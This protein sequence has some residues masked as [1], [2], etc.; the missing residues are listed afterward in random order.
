MV[1]G[2]S[3]DAPFNGAREEP[4]HDAFG[5]LP[6]LAPPLI[7]DPRV[8]GSITQPEIIVR[9]KLQT[10][11]LDPATTSRLIPDCPKDLWLFRATRDDGFRLSVATHAEP[12]SGQY[13]C[14][15]LRIVPEAMINRHFD[16]D[17][18]AL[19]LGIEM[20][21]KGSF[22]RMTGIAGPR[23]IEAFEKI[24]F[25]KY[26][27]LP[28]L[29]YRVG[30]N[31]DL[32]TMGFIVDALTA[33]EDEFG[34]MAITGQDAGHGDLSNGEKSLDYIADRFVGSGKLNTGEPTGHGNFALL[35]GMFKGLGKNL[36]DS[37]IALFGCGNVGGPLLVRI[38]EHG[39]QDIFVC[40]GVD[41]KRR[42]LA[43]SLGINKV[44][45]E[46]R[47]EELLNYKI[48]AV[49]FN[50]LGKSL[51]NATI[52]AI[53]NNPHIQIVSG[54]ENMIWPDQSQEERFLEARKIMSPTELCG[55][56]GWLA[57]A[58]ESLARRAGDETFSMRQMLKPLDKMAEVG[59][60]VVKEI[61]QGGYEL[62]YAQALMKVY[63]HHDA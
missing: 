53:C 57:A 54:C 22:A 49:V 36:V 58:E 52:K 27:V 1:N 34:V 31:K 13:N 28:P 14:G 32:E 45:P 29:G 48:D 18:M 24:Q 2:P 3:S 11:I 50:T 5:A 23:V 47:K 19:R 59:E 25:G 33:F 43:N 51:D 38:L 56:G 6:H 39:M 60:R 63:D 26:V 17:I 9:K 10:E 20:D 42:M 40:E 44:F 61:V 8:I 35:K 41:E 15:G 21:N 16:S 55:M 62:S 37:N 12:D 7:N 4:L 30:E 46:E